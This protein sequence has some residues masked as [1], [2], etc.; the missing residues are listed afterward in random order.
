MVRC[1]ASEQPV[2]DR[3]AAPFLKLPV[4][5]APDFSF[6]DS[7]PNVWLFEFS[8]AIL[9]VVIAA[10]LACSLCVNMINPLPGHRRTFRGCRFLGDPR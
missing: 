7:T 2:Q 4:D 6:H 10:R 9:L 3:D 8:E 1:L 5:A